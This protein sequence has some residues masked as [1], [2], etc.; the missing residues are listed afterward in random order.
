MNYNFDV[1][2]VFP[3]V[4]NEE[5]VW[6]ETYEK[7][8]AR[9][10]ARPAAAG[11]RFADWGLISFLVKGIIKNLDWIRYIFLIV[12]NPEQVP[13]SIQK[14]VDKGKVKVVLHKD[15]IPEQFLPTFNSTTIEQFLH[16]IPGLADH[17]I[18]GND[19]MYPL[20]PMKKSQ[21]FVDEEHIRINYHIRD[22]S[23]SKK[24]QFDK[25][26]LRSC[27]IIKEHWGLLPVDWVKYYVRPF[28]SVTPMIKSHN[29]M[30]ADKLKDIIYP[31]IGPIRTDR[32]VNQYIFPNYEIL[33]NNA[34]TSD[35]NFTYK[36]TSCQLDTLIKTIKD[37][38]VDLL[39]FNDSDGI[40]RASLYSHRKDI[41]HA[42]AERLQVAE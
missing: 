6:R 17:F 32:Q 20:N 14:Y 36:S 42:F 1:D 4:N 29:Q 11:A 9:R 3:Y 28:H 18:Y 19:D 15:F 34:E 12:S 8:C 22:F 38:T 41:Q 33:V 25:V 5:K 21:F 24:A 27:N 7:D 26:T 39:C 37:P 31:N 2:Y 40:Y 23:K 10:K 16:L 30:V 13:N 35:I